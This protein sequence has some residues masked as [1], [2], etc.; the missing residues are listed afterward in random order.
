MTTHNN[1]IG[2]RESSSSSPKQED[3][4]P[5]PPSTNGENTNQKPNGETNGTPELGGERD[6]PP[7]PQQGDNHHQHS[8]DQEEESTSHPFGSFCGT[9]YK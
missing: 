7:P 8:K 4:L 2:D 3:S 1:H 5:T 6:Q 9:T